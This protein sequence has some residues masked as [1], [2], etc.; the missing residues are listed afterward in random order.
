MLLRFKSLEEVISHYFQMPQAVKP[1][2][3]KMAWS[4]WLK[5]K[6]VVKG[7]HEKHKT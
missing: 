1:N 7:P 3:W 5:T 2:I 6:F 4:K